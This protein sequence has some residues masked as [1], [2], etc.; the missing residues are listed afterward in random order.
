MKNINEFA[1]D[2]GPE[3]IFSVYDSKTGMKGYIV[4]DNT[5][6][7]LA[8]GGT[9]MTPNLELETVFRL[10][11]TMT[12]KGSLVDINQG[13][14]KAGIV[15]DPNSPNKK[16]IVKAFAKKVKS[17]VPEEYVPGLDIGMNEGDAAK[18]VEE[19]E[20]TKASAGRPQVLGGAPYDEWGVAGYGVAESTEALCEYYNWD[21]TDQ[22]I[23]IQGFGAVGKAVAKFLSEKGANI[24]AASTVSGAVHD[25]DGL[26][27]KKLIELQEEHGDD[28]V[29]HYDGGEEIELGKE[30]FVEADIVIPAAV[31]EVIDRNN[32]DQLK[33]DA[34]VQAA[35]MPVTEDAEKW[36]HKN[37]IIN[38][39]DFLANAGAVVAAGHEMFTRYG[40]LGPDRG[41]I[42]D[43]VTQRLKSNTVT[44]LEEVEST[45]KLPREI[46][47]D[48]A[49]ARVL[50]AMELRGR[51]NDEMREKYSDLL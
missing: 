13:G 3:K 2:F 40:P 43:D 21:L 41:E 4:I 49:K 5:A 46:V 35:N 19:L 30:L 22:D 34:I 25:S 18:I 51:L 11:R 27:V 36:L 12:W 9:R 24:V 8:K 23:T 37:N 6:R 14:G 50:E 10:A 29:K 17:V 33:G 15:A 32:V 31:E 45:D 38:I 1:D 42:Y 26:N 47:M 44:L 28:C 16:E 7:G 20:D 48:I 39:P